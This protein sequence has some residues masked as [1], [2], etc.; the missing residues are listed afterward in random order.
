MH[1]N[2]SQECSQ[3]MAGIVL[4]YPPVVTKEKNRQRVTSNPRQLESVLDARGA[5]TK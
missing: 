3:N 2:Y 4:C 5:L 1:C